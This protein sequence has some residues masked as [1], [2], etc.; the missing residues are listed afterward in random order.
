MEAKL[1]II[2][3]EGIRAKNVFQDTKEEGSQKELYLPRLA[4]D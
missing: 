2:S 1:F 3:G 4:P